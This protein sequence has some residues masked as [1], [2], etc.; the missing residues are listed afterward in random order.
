MT[1]NEARRTRHPWTQETMPR[2]TGPWTRPVCGRQ[3]GLNPFLSHSMNFSAIHSVIPIARRRE[4]RAL[5]SSLIPTCGP[6]WQGRGAWLMRRVPSG[7]PCPAWH[8]MTTRCARCIIP[9]SS[10][11]KKIQTELAPHAGARAVCA[12]R[13]ISRASQV[14]VDDVG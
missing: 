9:V 6:E 5:S 11:A 2:G 14:S 13:G 7:V 12:D 3:N 10:R 1:R 4:R 8:R